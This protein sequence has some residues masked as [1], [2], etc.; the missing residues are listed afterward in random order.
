[1]PSARRS[2]G[3][4]CRSAETGGTARQKV[5]ALRVVSRARVTAATGP[6]QRCGQ[7]FPNGQA[8]KEIHGQKDPTEPPPSSPSAPSSAAAA[9]RPPVRPGDALSLTL[10]VPD[11]AR[12]RDFYESVLGWSAAPGRVDDGWQV[13][14]AE[15]RALI[16]GDW[17]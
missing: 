15:T 17:T 3:L 10:Q 9:P 4:S 2:P 12:A 8:G 6:S 13:A 16:E 1:M 14:V 5:T 7:G 11:G